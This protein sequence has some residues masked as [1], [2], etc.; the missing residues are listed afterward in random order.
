MSAAAS[1]CVKVPAEPETSEISA[2]SNVIN[3]VTEAL[4]G[5]ELQ[6]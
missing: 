6:T 4:L 1:A 2:A 3:D 5:Q